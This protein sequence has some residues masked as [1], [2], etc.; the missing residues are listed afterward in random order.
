MTVNEFFEMLDALRFDSDLYETDPELKS[1]IQY[2]YP[3]FRKVYNRLCE[4]GYCELDE[5]NTNLNEAKL[6]KVI[7][8]SVERAW[9]NMTK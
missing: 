2:T 9:N 1:M 8:E 5:C 3:L 6:R 4:H 7:S